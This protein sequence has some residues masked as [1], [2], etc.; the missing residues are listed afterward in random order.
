MIYATQHARETVNAAMAGMGRRGLPT[1][2]RPLPLPTA[3]ATAHTAIAGLAN[4]AYFVVVSTIEP[5]KNHALLL[6]VWK[7]LVVQQGRAAPHLVLVGARGFDADRV[8]AVID[9]DAQLRLHVHEVSGLSSPALASLLIGA[10]ALLSPSLAEGFGLPVLEAN[11]LGVPTIASDI[12]AHREVANATTV[13][14]PGDDDPAWER[15]IVAHMAR[16]H[17]GLPE[18]PAAASEQAYCDDVLAFT[19]RVAA[20]ILALS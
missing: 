6:R 7:R 18:I 20:D 10:N 8:L 11:L 9:H 13:L 5:R 2:V 1:L 15:A 17:R 4:C 12:A 14:L 3:F 19:H 16:V